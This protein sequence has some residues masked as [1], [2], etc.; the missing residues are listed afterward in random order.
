MLA[1]AKLGMTFEKEKNNT[2]ILE[3]SDE[4]TV[5]SKWKREADTALMLLNTV[6]EEHPG[7]PWALLAKK[8]LEVPIGWKWT[9]EFTDLAPPPQRRP[10]NNNNNPRPPRDDQKRMIPKAPKRPVPKL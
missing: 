6:A 10:G 4:I 5:G 3:S 2:W 8:E 7:T 9:E 1:K